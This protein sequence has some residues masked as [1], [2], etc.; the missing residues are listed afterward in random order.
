MLTDTI[1]KNAFPKL[2]PKTRKMV[3]D[4]IGPALTRYDI[5]TPKRLAAFLGQTAHE[6]GMFAHR[7]E[8]LNYSAQGLIRTWPTR[9][10]EAN[11]SYYA[12]DPTR[13]ANR[14]YGGR[15]GNLPETSGDAARWIGRGFLQVTGKANYQSFATAM[16]MTLDEAVAYLETDIGAFM[17]A[18]WFWDREA[19][20]QYADK[21]Q[22]TVISKRIN[23]GTNGLADRIALSNACLKALS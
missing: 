12:R 21:W 22:I 4:A 11:A 19:L 5:T 9:F 20:N 23:G 14:V 10:N 7:L 8:N 6:S 1:L 18:A 17:S 16:G 2:S 13:I 15:L 3:L